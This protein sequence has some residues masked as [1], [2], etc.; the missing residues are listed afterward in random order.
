MNRIWYLVIDFTLCGVEMS[1][2]REKHHG[3][4]LLVSLMNIRIC[5]D[6]KYKIMIEVVYEL[7][8]SSKNCFRVDQN[9]YKGSPLAEVVST[10]FHNCL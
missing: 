2:K 8:V 4:V 9:G 5:F 1:K 10:M 6:I 7:V 3:S